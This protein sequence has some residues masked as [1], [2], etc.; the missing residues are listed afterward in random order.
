MLAPTYYPVI[1]ALIGIGTPAM[2]IVHDNRIVPISDIPKPQ[3]AAGLTPEM[4]H[5]AEKHWNKVTDSKAMRRMKRPK[6]RI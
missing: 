1:S 2:V 5:I 3:G 6:R 4:K